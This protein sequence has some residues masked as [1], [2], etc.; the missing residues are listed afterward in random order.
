MQL[1]VKKMKSWDLTNTAPRKG[2]LPNFVVPPEPLKCNSTKRGTTRRRRRSLISKRCIKKLGW[3]QRTRLAHVGMGMEHPIPR[4]K[5]ASKI[6]RDDVSIRWPLNLANLCTMHV[7]HCEYVLLANGSHS[8]SDLL[9]N[10]S[11]SESYLLLTGLPFAIADD[12]ELQQWVDD[13]VVAVKV[14]LTSQK[15]YISLRWAGNI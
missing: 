4:S 5:L 15:D 10:L 14:G 11:H 8:E 12:P 9:A 3:L 6:G 13:L 7:C 2:V 1:N